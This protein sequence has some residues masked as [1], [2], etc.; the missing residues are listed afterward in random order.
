MEKNRIIL[1]CRVRGKDMSGI[2]GTILRRPRLPWLGK[3]KVYLDCNLVADGQVMIPGF[4][5]KLWRWQFYPLDPVVDRLTNAVDRFAR[6][7]DT[8][9]EE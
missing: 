3:Y 2:T 6:A 1:G 4:E 7:V 8:A 9:L 5:K